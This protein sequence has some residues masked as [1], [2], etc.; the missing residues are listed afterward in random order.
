M[1]I[2]LIAI[3]LLCTWTQ[4]GADPQTPS[5]FVGRLI[6]RIE[7]SGNR[8]TR[9]YIIRREL[10]LKVG[11]PLE[12]QFVE[13]DLRRLENLD[14]FSS[15]KVLAA[16][17]GDGVA[18]EV[19]VREMP[20]LVPYIKWDITDEDGWSLG[21][22]IKSVNML[23]MDLY[24]EGFALF[25]GKTLFLLD[26]SNPWITGDHLSLDLDLSR[27]ERKNELDGFRE[28]SLEFSPWVGI[29]AGEQGRV[30]FGFSYF[31]VESDASGFTLSAD[32]LDHLVR[33]GAGVGYDSRDRWGDPYRG[34]LNELQVLKTGGIL[35]GDGDFWTGNFDL[36]RFQPITSTHTLVLAGLATLQS[37][38]IG[39]DLPVYMDFHLGGSNSIRGHAVDKLGRVLHGSNQLI[40]T[41]EYRFPLLAKSEYSFWGQAT[42]LG[43]AGAFFADAGLA[44]SRKEDFEAG[45]ART[46]FGLG[47]RVLLPVVD[48]SR[49]DLGFDEEG[50]WRLHFAVFSKMRAQRLRLR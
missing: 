29:Y 7:L 39:R 27:I 23:G 43:L 46:G 14:I 41:A 22:A 12:L 6:T 4:T 5:A 13:G 11:E 15:A 21:P 1:K 26:L 50:N 18:L 8:F 19:R 24:L 17:D 33:V 37:G 28:T 34:W 32:R 49:L 38:R 45:R 40:F 31:Q 10:R 16:A 36:R 47:L 25:G 35:P 44:W 20:P 3:L 48:M 2:L 9:E 42:N 30:K